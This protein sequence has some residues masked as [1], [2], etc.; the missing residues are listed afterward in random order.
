MKKLGFIDLFIDEWHANNYPA[1]IKTARRGTE[2]ELA[3]AWEKAPQNG[4][5]LEKWCADFGVTPLKS[6][7]EVVEKS[8]AV[9]V[10]APSNPEVHRE[11]AEI[12]LKS[13]KPVFVDK[14]FAPSKA[15][16]E[17]MFELAA[18]HNTPLMSSSA[19]RFSTELDAYRNKPG[20]TYM[21]TTGGGRSFWEYS[22][23]QIEM[24]VSVLGTGAKRIM[25]CG[26]NDVEHMVIQYEDDRRAS[27]TYTPNA[28]FTTRLVHE[29]KM[30]VNPQCSDFFPI[31]LS[32]ILDFF[33]T[34]KS[35]IDTAQT[36]EIAALVA[37]GIKALEAKNVWHDL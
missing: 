7:E 33:A 25:Q 14:P 2:F 3:Y 5:P 18:K 1:W 26:A 34:G 12:P 4:R 32:E 37:A 24:I 36:I 22:I 11:L 29:G 9:F 35:P 16:A 6:M 20:T 30:I 10:L 28:P 23:H 21:E 13:G 27:V 31:L 17:A 15:D 8:D 19:L